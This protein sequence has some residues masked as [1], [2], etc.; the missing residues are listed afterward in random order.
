MNK[1]LILK[2]TKIVC[3]MGSLMKMEIKRVWEYYY[4]KI[5]GFMKVNGEMM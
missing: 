2:D 3:I 1:M 4:T 5:I